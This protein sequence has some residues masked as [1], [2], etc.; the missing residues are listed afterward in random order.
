MY[1]GFEGQ[2][3]SIESRV[4]G[5]R[6]PAVEHPPELVA[7]ARCAHFQARFQRLR[8][9]WNSQLRAWRR[10]GKRLALWGAG[11]K[12]VMFLNTVEEAR[13]IDLV[14]DVNPRK[15]G[16]HV[17]GSGQTIASPE[18]LA[19]QRP[20]VVLFMNPAYVSEIRARVLA[21]CPACEILPVLES[22]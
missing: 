17:S 7:P 9:D 2:M 3:L 6:R 20:D 1:F 21:D 12:G 5:H 15:H 4:A 18:A 22:D 10:A 14:F 13:T 19:S 16:R 8:D 11:T